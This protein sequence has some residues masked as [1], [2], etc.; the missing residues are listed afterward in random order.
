MKASFALATLAWLAF[1]V[2]AAPLAEAKAEAAAEAE[3]EA[4]PQIA[5]L[6][7]RTTI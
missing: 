2:H 3:A 1:N 4:D 6:H 7:V 5:F